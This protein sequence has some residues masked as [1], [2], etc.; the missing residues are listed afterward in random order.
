MT[1]LD[2]GSTAIGAKDTALSI[3]GIIASVSPGL[4]EERRFRSSGDPLTPGE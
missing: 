3:D 1:G 2:D 4:K